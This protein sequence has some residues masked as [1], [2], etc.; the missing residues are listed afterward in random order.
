MRWPV[1]FGIVAGCAL[2]EL[3]PDEQAVR[4]DLCGYLASESPECDDAEGPECFHVVCSWN[5]G[6]QPV[7]GNPSQSAWT[8]PDALGRAIDLCNSGGDAEFQLGDGNCAEGPS[9]TGDADFDFG[10]HC[11][12]LNEGRR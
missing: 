11:R 9:D 12:S 1:L 4:T 10:A 7:C 6:A 3:T 5:F 2:G 8:S